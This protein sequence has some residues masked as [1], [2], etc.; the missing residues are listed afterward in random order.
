MQ[1]GSN[2]FG[3]HIG[4][5]WRYGHWVLCK[6]NLLTWVITIY[7]SASYLKQTDG[8]FREEH[9]LPLRRLFP[10]ICN[11][12]GYYE[13]SNRAPRKPLDRMKAVKLSPRQFPQQHDGTSCGIFILQGIENI[14]RNKDQQWNWNKD[15]VPGLRKDMA[16]E[17]FGCLI[18]ED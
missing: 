12:S 2:P 9:V 7:D 17:I 11:Q 1:S 4:K 5:M 10:L 13:V 14:M 3:A 16:F 15:T 18:E 8:K 6:V